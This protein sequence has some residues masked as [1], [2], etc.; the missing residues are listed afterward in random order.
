MIQN[1]VRC[2]LL[3][4][5]LVAPT[6]AVSE[7]AS[8]DIVIYGGTASGIAAVR[9]AVSHGHSVILIV[10]ETFIGGMMT[11][12]LGASDKGV[13]WTVGGLARSFF[14]DVYQHYEDPKTW[15]RETRAEYLPKHGLIYRESM[16]CQWFFEPHVARL[17]FEKWLTDSGAKV[18]RGERLNRAKG[19]VTKDAGVI[20]AITMES[21]LGIRG[22]YF[23]DATYEGDLMAAA[24]VAYTVGREANTAFNETMNGIQIDETGSAHISPYIV[25]GDAR[26]GLLPRVEARPYGPHGAADHRFQAYNFRLCLTTEP[27]NRVPITKPANYNPLNYELMLRDMQRKKNLT[28]GKGYFT[29]VPM[30]NLKTDSNNA[31]TFSTDY[32]AGSYGWPEA[33]YAERERILA[34][35]R[36]YV[37][38]FFWFLGND[39]RVPEAFRQDV[40]RWGLAKD[41]FTDN[42]H[43]PTQLY[44]REARR[45]IGVHVMNENNFPLK[46]AD[47]KGRKIASDARE[48]VKDIIAVGSYALDSHKVGMFVDDQG[49]LV[50]EGHF[51]RGVKPYGISYRSLLPKAD[52]CQNLLVSVCVSATHVAYGSMRMESVYME[53]GQAAAAAASLSLEHSTTPHD[54]AYPVL[55]ERLKAGRAML[56]PTEPKAEAKESNAPIAVDQ[57][58]LDLELLVERKIITNA[59]DWIDKT[60]F[61][62]ELVS[63]LII[64]SASQFQ[65]VTKID[66]AISILEQEGII[67][68][69]AYWNKHAAEGQ[70]CGAGNTL[71][72][73][74]NLAVKLRAPSKKR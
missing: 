68:S 38:G 58:K 4:L 71:T 65:P 55:A 70:T 59:G 43:W 13:Y 22:K 19:G 25:E 18:L 54:L 74:Q 62:G 10:P 1:S 11:G 32:I 24:G 14:E 73:I 30:P 20:R 61:D 64:K 40:A 72:L 66:E 52:Q 5:G 17:I 39:P 56:D 50:W 42:D 46:S 44:V 60:S 33:S 3:S 9:E 15:T 6:I 2:F 57:H 26:S 31:G 67:K 12:G 21:G 8:A 48:P 51:F 45:M 7:E 16:K 29:R 47:A 49:Q 28:P 37:Q 23:I 53:M 34:E 41:E 36:G 35:H 63:A 69:L 27:A